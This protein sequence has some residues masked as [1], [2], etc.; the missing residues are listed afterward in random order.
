MAV[1]PYFRKEPAP[2]HDRG[3]SR[4]ISDRLWAAVYVRG[5][6]KCVWC[7]HELTAADHSIDHFDG[8]RRNNKPDNLLPS[9]IGCNSKRGETHETQ[10]A[11][12]ASF[13]EYL[14]AKGSSLAAAMKRATKQLRTPIPHGTPRYSKLHRGPVVGAWAP[15]DA[16]IDAVIKE[17][18][19]GKVS[20]IDRLTQRRDAGKL[21]SARSREHRKGGVASSGA[22]PFDDDADPFGDIE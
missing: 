4:D 16:R 11:A 7:D 13:D 5:D 3:S 1:H 12:N 9:H 20:G 18:S 22:T 19:P 14:R 15:G 10:E 2:R 8:N 6:K 21:R 17:F